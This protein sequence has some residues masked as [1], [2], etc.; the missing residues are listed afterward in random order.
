MSSVQ[1]FAISSA[2]SGVTP[3]AT[4]PAALDA[5]SATIAA[6]ASSP[7]PGV[8]QTWAMSCQT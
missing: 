8:C 2:T 1:L 3:R 5:G 4:R 6:A 7:A